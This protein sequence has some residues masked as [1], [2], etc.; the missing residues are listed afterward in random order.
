MQAGF[1]EQCLE[2]RHVAFRG[3]DDEGGV[4]VIC[5]HKAIAA[6]AVQMPAEAAGA[7][8]EQL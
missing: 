7:A 8:V 1:V 5:Q 3:I 4:I 6:D 2:R